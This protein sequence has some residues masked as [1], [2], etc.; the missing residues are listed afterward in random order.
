MAEKKSTKV[1]AEERTERVLKSLRS[2]G[3]L[4][5]AAY[6]LED[7][8]VDQIF[9]GIETE[10]RKQRGRFGATRPFCFRDDENGKSSQD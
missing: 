8:Q 2:L 10:I 3:D 5:R 1:R 9:E 4:S 7:R 6:V